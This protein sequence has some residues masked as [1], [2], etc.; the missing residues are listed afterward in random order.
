MAS[1]D[2]TITGG[3]EMELDYNDIFDEIESGIEYKV[4][5]MIDDAATNVDVG[6][7]ADHLL[8]EYIRIENPC[9]LGQLF[10]QAVQKACTRKE[11]TPEVDWT[12]VRDEIRVVVHNEVRSAMKSVL[13]EATRLLTA[14]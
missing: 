2:I 14:A 11:I 6:A 10:E 1:Y 5:Q 3:A 4:E 8:S 9:G 13:S 12:D 7:E